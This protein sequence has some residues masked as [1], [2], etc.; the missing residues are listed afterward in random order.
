MPPTPP[1]TGSE[2]SR[3]A[4]CDRPEHIRRSKSSYWEEILSFLRRY[5]R[6]HWSVLHH[7]DFKDR[8]FSFLMLL[9]KAG[10]IATEEA[11]DLVSR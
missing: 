10:G 5:L 4:R 7:A 2:W 11:A 3:L 6:A 1:G 9:E 8:A